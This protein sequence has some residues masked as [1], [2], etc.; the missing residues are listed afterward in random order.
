[1][2]VPGKAGPLAIPMLYYI[3]LG[4]GALEDRS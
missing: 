1:M 2:F 4:S 3:I